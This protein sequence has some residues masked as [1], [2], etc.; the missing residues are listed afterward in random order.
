MADAAA[1]SA[2]ETAEAADYCYR[3]AEVVDGQKTMVTAVDVAPSWATIQ[4]TDPV[5]ND[6]IP[7]LN[8]RT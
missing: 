1:M 6:G 4:D 8:Y 7:G 2:A 3:T 5:D